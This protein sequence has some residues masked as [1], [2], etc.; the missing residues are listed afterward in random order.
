[1]RTAASESLYRANKHIE[2]RLPDTEALYQLTYKSKHGDLLAKVA[3]VT[4][5]GKKDGEDVG[6]LLKGLSAAQA[7]LMGAMGFLQQLA[8]RSSGELLSPQDAAQLA[9][10]KCF[11]SDSLLGAGQVT[12]ISPPAV[13]EMDA[14]PRNLG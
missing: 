11:S 9:R 10:F 8:F 6:S 7:S 5:P 14:T 13:E 2:N 1:M 3:S 12:P 4:T